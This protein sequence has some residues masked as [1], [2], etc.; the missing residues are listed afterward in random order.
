MRFD[1][2]MVRRKTYLSEVTFQ[3]ENRLAGLSEKFI[4]FAELLTLSINGGVFDT[5]GIRFGT[6]AAS[7]TGSLSFILE[8]RQGSQLIENRHFSQARVTT[9]KHLELLEAWYR[10][11][12]SRFA[13]TRNADLT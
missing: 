10:I 8:R 12:N 11:M 7:R 5:T 2:G 6:D 3:S 13:T 9:E 4:R 1:P